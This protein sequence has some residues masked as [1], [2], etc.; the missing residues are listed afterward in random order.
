MNAYFC[1]SELFFA[2]FFQKSLLHVIEGLGEI[3]INLLRINETSGF[4]PQCILLLFAIVTELHNR[5][6]LVNALTTFDH[7][8]KELAELVGS[9]KNLGLFPGVN[10]IEDHH[11]FF[12]IEFL[13]CK[14]DQIGLDLAGLLA[15]DTVYSLVARVGNLFCVFGKLDLR[16]EGIAVSVLY[17]GKFIYA[18]ECR[19]VIGCDQLGSDAPGIDL[20]ILCLQAFDKIF[21]KI[22][23]CRMVASSKPAAA[24]IL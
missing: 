13:I 8:N 6:R 9:S 7:R 2:H 15:V 18:A 16:L 23:G 21:I 3:Y 20:G 10:R 12:R 11:S 24:S 17:S 19:I 22:A 14:A 4:I 1:L 5:W